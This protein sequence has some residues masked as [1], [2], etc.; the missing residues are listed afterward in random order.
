MAPA[1][2]E[3]AAR[4]EAEAALRALPFPLS[5]SRPNVQRA[6]EHVK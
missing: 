4:A 6:G 3:E 2:E 5:Q 1:M